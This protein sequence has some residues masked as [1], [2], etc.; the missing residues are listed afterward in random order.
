VDVL[1]LSDGT[2]PSLEMRVA[3]MVPGLRVAPCNVAD[4]DRMRRVIPVLNVLTHP[5]HLHG[6]DMPRSVERSR[7]ADWTR[8]IALARQWAVDR[9]TPYCELRAEDLAADP[10]Q[11]RNRLLQLWRE[12][13]L[14]GVAGFVPSDAP[15][16]ERRPWENPV[17]AI[18]GLLAGDL[19]YR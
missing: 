3:G 9:G 14:R 16:V 19:G 15:P 7:A 17:L 4:L 18:T 1:L 6:R 13:G 8:R 2:D 10:V 12:P 11:A 5:S